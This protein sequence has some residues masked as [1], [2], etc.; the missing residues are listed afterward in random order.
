MKDQRQIMYPDAMRKPLL[1]KKKDTMT[2]FQTG[3]TFSKTVTFDIDSVSRFATL[4]GD[5]SPLHHDAEFS[6]NTRFKGLIVSATQSSSI[7]MGMVAT[8]L[9]QRTGAL[10]LEFNYQFKKAVMAGETTVMQWTIVSIEENPSLRGDLISFKGV[11]LNEKQQ[12]C[13]TAQARCVA[14]PEN[15]L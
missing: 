8:F 14:L 11:L 6:K 10:G 3:E 5:L 2:H 15:L 9:T 7:M 13:I 1:L 12:E 4:T